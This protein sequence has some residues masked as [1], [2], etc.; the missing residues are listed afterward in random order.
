MRRT[1]RE[2]ERGMK[3]EAV[4]GEE[5][6]LRRTSDWASTRDAERLKSALLKFIIA[7]TKETPQNVYRSPNKKGAL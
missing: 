6:W 1:E 4:E 5:H 2:R 7:P 3:V